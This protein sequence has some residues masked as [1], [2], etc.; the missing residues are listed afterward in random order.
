M[1]SPFWTDQAQ[2]H[3]S[4]LWIPPTDSLEYVDYGSWFSVLEQPALQSSCLVVDGPASPSST[5]YLKALKIRLYP[6]ASQR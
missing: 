1:T 6:N 2:F 5:D 4:N 3:A